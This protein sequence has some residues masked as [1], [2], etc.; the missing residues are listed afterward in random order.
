MKWL[1]S[2]V[3]VRMVAFVAVLLFFSCET[4]SSAMA[5]LFRIELPQLEGSYSYGQSSAIVPI[6]LGTPL[7]D[8]KNI[9]LELSGVHNSG[10]WVGDMVEDLYEGPRGGFLYARM[11]SESTWSLHTWP[12]QWIGHYNGNGDG[13]FTATMTLSR[14]GG[15]SDWSFLRDGVTDLTFIHDVQGGWGSFTTQPSFNFT[16]VT[17]VVDA[18]PIPEPSTLTLLGMGAISLIFFWRRRK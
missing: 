8:L 18:T 13:S 5:N 17:L 4:P 2:K 7:T 9:Q 11:D 16:D 10:W 14:L 1:Y 12:S 15:G 3:V 6:N